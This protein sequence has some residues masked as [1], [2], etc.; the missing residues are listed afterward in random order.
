M[1]RIEP[2][3]RKSMSKDGLNASANVKS[4]VPLTTSE[5]E[6][7]MKD[8]NEEDEKIAIGAGTATVVEIE[9]GSAIGLRPIALIVTCLLDPEIQGSISPRI[10]HPLRLCQWTRNHSRKLPCKCS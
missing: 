1:K 6:S 3:E 8:T 5:S 10:Q 2:E 4:S 9:T 7:E